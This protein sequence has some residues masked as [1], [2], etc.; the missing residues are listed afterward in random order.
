[1]FL[2][3]V[4]QGLLRPPMC[5]ACGAPAPGAWPCCPR[6]LPPGTGGVGPWPLAADPDLVLWTLGPYRDALRAAVLAGK[7]DGQPAAL[8]EL[9][10]RLGGALAVAGVGA[11]LVT[12]VAAGRTAGPPRDHAERIAAG[13]A[14]ALDVPLV[15]LLAPAGGRDLARHRP[16]AAALPAAVS[17]WSTTWPPPAAP[18]PA[19]PPPCA[20]SAPARSKPPSSPH[21][22]PPS[23]QPPSAQPHPPAPAH[24]PTL[25]ATRR[26]RPGA[27]CDRGT[28]NVWPGCPEVEV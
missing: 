27:A 12:Y 14:T 17:C 28:G 1:M 18:S 16:P 26:P 22:Q 13:V 8:A 24:L 6:C 4:L 11:D 3:D 2:V 19:P 25:P 23:A 21:P 15:G 7:F 20:S 9:G 10:R 5:L